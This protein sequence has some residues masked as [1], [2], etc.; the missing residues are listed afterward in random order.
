MS[1]TIRNGKV[2]SPAD[3]KIRAEYFNRLL[4]NGKEELS[5]LVSKGVL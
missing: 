3:D 5:V 4:E 2:L 1:V